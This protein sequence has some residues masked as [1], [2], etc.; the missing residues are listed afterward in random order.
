MPNNNDLSILIKILLEQSS[1]TSLK[2][3][4]ENLI[5]NLQ[6]KI[7]TLNININSTGFKELSA[8]LSQLTSNTESKI[9]I[10]NDL[11]NQT[12]NLTGKNISKQS[13]VNVNGVDA[14]LI[15]EINQGLGRTKK[16]VQELKE[17]GNTIVTTT[18]NSK[19]IDKAIEK[20]NQFK[21]KTEQAINSLRAKYGDGIFNAQKLTGTDRILSQVN[22]ITTDTKGWV[23]VTKNW[24]LELIKVENKLKSLDQQMN[25]NKLLTDQ[26]NKANLFDTGYNNRIQDIKVRAVVDSRDITKLEK[27]F[28]RLNEKIK[29][30]L[31]NNDTKAFDRYSKEIVNLKQQYM[32]LIKLEKESNSLQAQQMKFNSGL[33][34]LL[35]GKV[36]QFINSV[37]LQRIKDLIAN[38][39]NLDKVSL[40]HIRNEI[41]QL[42]R[43]AN[44]ILSTKSLSE[45]IKLTQS[46]Y[47]NSFTRFEGTKQFST[48]DTSQVQIYN[49]LKQQ[50]Q[51]ISTV[52]PNA[53][54]E[55][56][57][58]GKEFENLKIKSQQSLDLSNQ[59]QLLNRTL[60]QMTADIHKFQRQYAGLYDATKLN[61]I[62]N[63]LKNLRVNPNLNNDI[64]NLKANL[65]ALQKEAYSSSLGL[66][67]TSKQVMSLGDA[68]KT[69]GNKFSIWIGMS[70]LVMGAL[71]KI[72]ESFSYTLE[73]TKLFTNLQMEMTNQNLKFNE[74]TQSALDYARAMGTT[75]SEVGLIS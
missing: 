10:I 27:D 26:R 34:K 66:N 9:K 57:R 29:T 40:Q 13:L 69:A 68:I 17:N 5:K 7:G 50:I 56:A 61:K 22:K 58:L 41:G 45:Q 67:Q 12:M 36:G 21:V 59:Q 51:S 44:K 38:L 15:T 25:K 2:T 39:N 70:T 1:K 54:N 24:E 60:T 11:L 35:Q 20:V 42:G 64:A 8:Q 63:D 65:S 4:V 52:T 43:D 47:S 16:L 53:I 19:E 37:E 72:Q 18:V 28:V 62:Q 31:S 33:D 32:D 73:Q 75:S 46:G 23:E 30:A 14:K 71:H 74:V 49:S 48:L 55:L 3:E 6:Q